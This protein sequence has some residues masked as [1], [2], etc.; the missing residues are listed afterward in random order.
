[1]GALGLVAL[2]PLCWL[3][4]PRF[5]IQYFVIG[6]W[7]WPLLAGWLAG[8]VPADGRGRFLMRAY[9]LALAVL[10]GA[11][12]LGAPREDLRAGAREAG[13]TTKGFPTR[14]TAIL[15]QPDHYRHT[16]PFLVYGGGSADAIHEP[17][18]VPLPARADERLV[19]LTRSA[20]PGGPGTS[21]RLWERVARGRR[22]A[23]TI[24]IDRHVSVHVYETAP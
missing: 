4:W 8:R 1:M 24:K 19:V 7:C 18:D 2:M 5:P 3:V 13:L 15:R 12:V 22:L 20:S 6:A 21:P 10:A 17:G 9:A 14:L 11:H 16:V 23:R